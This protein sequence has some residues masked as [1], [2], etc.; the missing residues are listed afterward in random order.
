MKQGEVDL[1]LLPFNCQ[2]LGIWHILK[3]HFIKCGNRFIRHGAFSPSISGLSV[4]RKAVFVGRTSDHIRLTW[5]S[6][7]RKGLHMSA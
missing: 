7:W 2:I 5:M 3:Q 6:D 4:M 1:Y